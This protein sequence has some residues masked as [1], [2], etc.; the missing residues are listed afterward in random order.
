MSSRAIS[1]VIMCKNE[2]AIIGQT[3][4]AALSLTKDI[5]VVDTGSTDGTLELLQ[6]KNVQIVNSAWTGYGPVKNTGIT[7]AKND[8][9]LNID[10]DEI[11]DLKL[12]QNINELRLDN[13]LEVYNIEFIN[14]LAEMPLRFGEWSGDWHI[15]LF[16][17]K[18]TCW[19]NAQVHEQ[20][21]HT[22][23]VT[24][25]K[26]KGCIHHKTINN[27]AA[28]RTKLDYYAKLNAKKYFESGH[29]NFAIKKYISPVFNFIKNFVFKLG[30]LDGKA[31]WIV[32]KENFVYTYKKYFY[33]QQMNSKQHD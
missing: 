17:R 24:V 18:N 4:D 21:V 33:L 23:P 14:Y 7:E 28:L 13:R 6:S 12:I 2:V 32:A 10:A 1:V 27:A 16:N 30:F 15:R 26:L 20:L 25:I 3:I 31:G 19:S 5:T 9:I 11:I 29:S 8:W 22:Q